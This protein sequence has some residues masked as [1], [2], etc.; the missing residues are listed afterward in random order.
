MPRDKYLQRMKKR[1]IIVHGWDGYPEE[2]WFPWLKKELEAKGFEVI[3]PQLPDPETPRIQKWVPALAKVVGTPDARTYFVGHSMG[4]QAIAR[5]LEKLP[6]G[7]AVGGIVSVAGFFK[8][9]TAEDDPDVQETDRLW[10]G[11]PID[12]MKVKSHFK[13]GIAIFSDNDPYVP[14]DNH[15][16]FKTKLGCDIVIEHGKGHFSG[17]TGTIELPA[18]LAA[19]IA[20]SS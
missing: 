13:K 15:D 11:A 1:V 16:D 8:R 7:V 3:V 12:L 5:Y 14:L 17:S 4:C 20:I 9:I 19:V 18:A 2:G 10:L 6:T